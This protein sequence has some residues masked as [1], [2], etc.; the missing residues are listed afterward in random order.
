MKLT[1]AMLRSH[2]A[3]EERVVIFALEWPDG[4]DVTEETLLR[5]IE[6]GLNIVWFAHEFLAGPLLAE[7]ERQRALLWAEVER[8]EAA[9]WAEFNRKEAPLWAEVVRKVASL[10]EE[11]VRKEAPLIASIIAQAEAIVE[12]RS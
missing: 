10:R 12:A 2:H 5:A 6:L 4:C 3:C 7:F 8:Q 11:Y 9:L 1:E